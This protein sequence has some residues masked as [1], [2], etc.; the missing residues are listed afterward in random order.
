M[1]VVF[2][3]A[4][5][6]VAAWSQPLTGAISGRVVTEDGQPVPRAAVLITASGKADRRVWINTD[7]EGNFRAEGL[8]AAAY[9]VIAS[10]PGYVVRPKSEAA[11]RR[12]GFNY[13]GEAVTVTMFIGGV[14]TG[15]VVNAA[16]EPVVGVPVVAERVRDED[17]R[18]LPAPEKVAASSQRQTDDRGVYR[19]YGLA[20]GSYVIC[21]GGSVG[22]STRP[23]PFEGRML[24]YH[25]S[26]TRDAAAEVTVR[27]GEEL[28][29]IDIRY[30]SERGY[31]IS[32]K[33]TG[34]P[35]T[36]GPVQ[37]VLRKAG[38]E[39]LMAM[40]SP[41]P[42]GAE[43]GYA[44]YG[45]PNG[46]YEIIAARDFPGAENAFASAPRRVVVN[47][48]DV[49]GIDLAL[50][51]MAALAGKVTV[52]KAARKCEAARDSRLN[53]VVVRARRDEPGAAG[54]AQP[55]PSWSQPSGE[56]SEAGA[57]S[58]RGLKA[59]RY[60][61]ETPLP[62]ADWYVKEM[63]LGGAPAAASDLG[64]NGVTLKS[65]ERLSG[66][67]ITLSGSAAGLK[68]KIVAEGEARLPARMLAHLAPAEPE[69]RDEVLR[70]AET[71]VESD[72]LFSFSNLAPG[73]YW[74]LARPIL[75]SEPN[76]KPARP[77]AWD[78]AERAKLRR[79]AE[80][81][82]VVIELKPCQRLSDYVL[83]YGK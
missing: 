75:D 7:E 1:F 58:I 44:L 69:A 77:A 33:I 54:A 62:G 13:I 27:G 24:I 64:R 18:P 23:T 38:S 30:R 46:E 71:R 21:A 10:A 55:S 16:G 17:G 67:L 82:N 76:D 57:F 79:E 66:A 37:I 83:R 68:G 39:L 28:S 19:W 47:G 22:I 61:L 9:V 78:A 8:D 31:I 26:A 52:E 70:F 42:S 45:V 25:P 36:G 35:T 14:I 60:R 74:L 43:S 73:K 50:A 72:G 80:A 81:A 34:L 49:G 20:P 6:N 48:R 4:V 5:L 59:G 51:P 56:A 11:A 53:E 15:R 63:R 2:L 12:A 29:G 65:G 40:T 32:G 41:Q 3:L